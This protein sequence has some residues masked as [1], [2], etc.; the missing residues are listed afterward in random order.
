MSRTIGDNDWV[1][2]I[3][4][5]G[6]R[7]LVQVRASLKIHIGQSHVSAAPLL[8]MPFG[9]NFRLETEGKKQDHKLVIDKRTVEQIDGDVASALADMRDEA[10]PETKN[11]AVLNDDGSAQSMDERAI[12]KMKLEGAQGETIVRALAQNSASFAGKTAFS[13]EK[14]MKKKAKRHLHHLTAARPTALSVVDM[15]TLKGPEKVCSLRRDSLGLLLSLSNVQPSSRALVL[16]ACVGL[17]AAAAAQRAGS[18]GAVLALH[19]QRPSLEAARWL[20]LDE[21][22]MRALGS[23]SLLQL[24]RCTAAGAAAGAA[25]GAAAGAAAAAWWRRRR[26]ARRRRFQS[27]SCRASSSR[28]R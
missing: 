5:S 24:L 20:N 27:G 22:C 23:C 10:G 12:K 9:A 13:Q 18:G 11:N 2:L 21:G 15:Y 17:L 14:W 19:L 7:R 28:R 25:E 6:E 8:G 26:I 4:S 16:D 1:L 3:M